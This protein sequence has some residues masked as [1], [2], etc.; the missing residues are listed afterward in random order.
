[1]FLP[2]TMYVYS[3][4]ST[5]SADF[6][7]LELVEGYLVLLVNYGSGTTRLNNTVVH[8]ADGK[9]HYIEII[10]MKSSIEMFVDECK[11]S[12]CM[13]LAAPT[14]TKEILNSTY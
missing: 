11:L 8:V 13:S 12:T 4:N 9:R 3:N 7:S 10:L 14:G 1:M 2:N 6:L 5:L